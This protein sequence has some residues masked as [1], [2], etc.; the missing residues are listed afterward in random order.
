MRSHV[1]YAGGSDERLHDV[2]AQPRGISASGWWL[3]VNAQTNG[4]SVSCWWL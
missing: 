4:I 3:K 1:D 2:S